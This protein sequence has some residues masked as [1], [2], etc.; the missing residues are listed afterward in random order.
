MVLVTGVEMQESVDRRS[1]AA[2]MWGKF[3]ALGGPQHL[4]D[5]AAPAIGFLAGYAAVNAKIG[6]LVALGVAGLISLYR[7][8]KGDSVKVVS[9]SLATVVVFSLFVGITGEG[10]GFYL[11]DLIICAVATAAFGITLL[12]G[13]PLSHWASRKLGLER[14]HT[15]DPEARIRLHHKVSLAWF[16][17]W[18]LHLLIMVPPYL[19]NKVVLLGTVALVLGKPALVV[20]LAVTWLWVRSPRTAA[21]LYVTDGSGNTRHVTR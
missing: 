3:R 15:G 4:L 12:S 17:F 14:A 7:L 6:V 19:A 21:P 10:R 8:I 5:G 2:E 11:P 18:A 16:A 9:V 20:M 1:T 13:R